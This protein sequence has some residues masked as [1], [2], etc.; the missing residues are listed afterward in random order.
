MHSF[1]VWQNS[2][3]RTLNA[4]ARE[5]SISARP[6]PL[7]ACVYNIAKPGIA[8][9]DLLKPLFLKGCGALWAKPYV[10]AVSW[11]DNLY[12]SF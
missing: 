9:I 7:A 5:I 4:F 3:L 1:K 2:T 12:A 11:L 10:C 8:P 6:V